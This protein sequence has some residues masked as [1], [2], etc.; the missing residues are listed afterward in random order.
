MNIP[1]NN[2]EDVPPITPHEASLSDDETRTPKTRRIHDLY[3]ATSELYLVC[4]LAQGDNI[5]FEVAIKYD[6]WRAAVDDEI[7]IIEKNDTWELTSLPR[8]HK[9]ISV[10]WV[11]KKKINPQGKVEKY[12]ARLVAK[13]YKQ[14]AGV[15]YEEVLA[16][17]ARMETIRLLIAL[18]AQSKWR[19]YQMDVKSAF[20]NGVLEEEVYIEQPLGYL[21]NKAL[22][23]LKQ[24]PRVWNTRI[25]QYF[26]SHG[27]V[28][29]PYEH[30]GVDPR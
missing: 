23:G 20:L 19:I 21:I 30:A 16:P 8:G 4:L 15:D 14:Q 1:C 17:V 22:Y 5:S 27:F 28:Q 29:C 6:K 13:G 24:A 12:K 10:K 18:A 26:K 7:R 2:D 3:E 9:A 11:Y 25:D